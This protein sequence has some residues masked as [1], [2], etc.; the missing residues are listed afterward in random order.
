MTLNIKLFGGPEISDDAG[1]L[2]RLPTRKSE[3]LFAYMVERKDQ[4][5]SRET[6]ADFL[7][8]Y[9]GPDQARASLRQEVSVLRKA[10]GPKNADSIFSQGD[11]IGFSQ[12]DAVVD[13]WR[14]RQ[15][16]LGTPSLAKQK[17][18]L[19]LYTAPF[20]NT[21]RIRSQPFS[22]CVLDL[23]RNCAAPLTAYYAQKENDNGN[24]CGS[25]PF[26]GK[27]S[28]CSFRKWSSKNSTY[29][30]SIRRL[31]VS[32][33]QEGSWP[34]YRGFGRLLRGGILRLRHMDHVIASVQD[35]ECV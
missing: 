35:Q 2:L 24:P 1:N 16:S 34:V 15:I 21:F 7:W 19:A 33:V 27:T 12:N 9:S 6:L 28:C 25:R 17:E 18:V 10:L 20:L 29:A 26:C 23:S 8:P 14:F 30:F 32:A 4:A 5:I 31:A 11:R 22:D 13:L 3:A